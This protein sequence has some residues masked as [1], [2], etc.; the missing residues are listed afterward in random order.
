MRYKYIL[1][2]I[3]NSVF[4]TRAAGLYMLLFAIAI[5]GATFV[6]N[7]FGTSSA[8]DIIFKSMWFE[9]LLVLFGGTILANIFRYRMIQ[10]KKWASLIFH[11][12]IIII[13]LGSGCYSPLESQTELQK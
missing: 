9:L 5:G 7:D 3:Y 11:S 8:Q 4:S 1:I 13:I 2:K 10:Q 12:S 6:E